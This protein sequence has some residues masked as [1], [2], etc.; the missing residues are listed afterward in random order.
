MC[1]SAESAWAKD[2]LYISEK[3]DNKIRQFLDCQGVGICQCWP[4]FTSH[5][6]EM[7]CCSLSFGSKVIFVENNNRFLAV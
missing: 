5:D 7:V 2:S 1:G 6:M 3:L 4:C